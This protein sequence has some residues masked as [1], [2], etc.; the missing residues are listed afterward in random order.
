MKNELKLLEESAISIFIENRV[1]SVLREIEKEALSFVPD[2]STSSSRKEIAS[3]ARK[4]SKSKVILDNAGKELTA[5]WKAQSKLV[6]ASRKESRD[7]L[8]LLRDTVRKP[9]TDWEDKKKQDELKEIRNNELI[10]AIEDANLLN[11][12][13]DREKEIER[14]RL[15]VIKEQEEYK[16]K[17][18]D[19]R[20]EID[21]VAREKEIEVKAIELGKK[22]AEEAAKREIENA[23][24]AEIQAKQ[25]Q[26]ELRVSAIRI[27]EQAELDRIAAIE[28]V[29]KDIRIAEQKVRD[30]IVKSKLKEQQ[31]RELEVYNR[32]QE[33]KRI[34]DEAD[35]MASDINYV[36]LIHSQSLS[37]LTN[38]GVDAKLAKKIIKLIV[39]GAVQHVSIN[40]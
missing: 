16:K 4:V 5:D 36:R 34:K 38:N 21:R 7:F 26:E 40:Y 9:L 18:A 1:D 39:V 13:F 28:K 31:R 11:D 29:E 23:R 35:R 6:D 32:E 17:I 25:K 3:I 30:D 14:Q 37:S 22:Q 12:I 24:I 15:L 33:E 10:K 19:E 20:A 27:A 2:L 8:D